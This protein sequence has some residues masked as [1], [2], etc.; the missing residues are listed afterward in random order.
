MILQSGFLVQGLM[1]ANAWLTQAECNFA[2][3]Y[4]VCKTGTAKRV[5]WGL[6]RTPGA[7]KAARRSQ[8]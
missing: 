7:V 1:H 3:V 5:C 6:V 8:G 2:A 4:M